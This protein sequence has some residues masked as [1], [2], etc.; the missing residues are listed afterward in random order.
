M[1][2]MVLNINYF[3]FQYWRCSQQCL[4]LWEPILEPLSPTPLWLRCRLETVT[5]SAGGYYSWTK[6]ENLD[7]CVNFETHISELYCNSEKVGVKVNMWVVCYDNL[8][9]MDSMPNKTHWAM[10]IL[11]LK[12]HILGSLV[13]HFSSV[14][15][16]NCYL[17]SCMSQGIC[18]SHGTWLF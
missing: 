3:F 8:Q 4:S 13:S 14:P 2:W 12:S 16:S 18:R 9:W 17:S 5:S 6:A 10:Y 1:Q 11:C 7:W 15:L